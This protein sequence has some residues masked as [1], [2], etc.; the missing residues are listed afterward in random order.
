[1][2]KKVYIEGMTC[3]HCAKHV[4]DALK[5]IDGVQSVKVDLKGKFAVIESAKPIED[6]SI[7]ATIEDAGY[8]PVKI[9]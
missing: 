4:E 3:N 8:E 5:E 7:K 1:M 2:T 9:E 6:A